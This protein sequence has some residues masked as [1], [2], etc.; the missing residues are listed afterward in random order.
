M[1]EPSSQP[2]ENFHPEEEDLD[3]KEMIRVV[4]SHSSLIFWMTFF[5]LALSGLYAFLWPK[6]YEAETTVKVPDISQTPQGMLRELVPMSGSGDPIETYVEVC[7]S[8]SVAWAV[9]KDLNLASKPDYQDLTGQEIVK[10]LLKGVVKVTN[11]KTSNLLSIAARSH[12]PQLAAALANTWAKEFIAV[13]L[14]LSHE[15]AQSKVDFLEDQARQLKTKLANPNLRLNDESKMDQ[16]IYAQLLEELQQAQI[17]EKVNDAGI[18]VVDEAKAPEKHV[19]PKKLLVLILGLF[20][21]LFG[22]IQLAFIL[23]RL[24]D[25]VKDVEKLKRRTGL[26]NY[27]IVP[28][29]REDYPASFGRPPASERFSSKYLIHNLVFDHAYYRESFKVLRTNITLAKAGKPLKVLS[30]FSPGPEEGKTLASANLSISLAQTG[31]KVLLVDADLRKSSVLKTF[32][33]P[34]NGVKAGLPL[35]LTGQKNWKDMVQPSGVENLDLL[36]NSVSPPN[37]AELLGSEAMKKLVGEMKLSY[38]FVIFDGAPVLPVT[39]SVVLST[40]LDGVILLARFNQTRLAAVLHALDHFQRV[41]VQVLGTVLNDIPL[42]KSI[43]GY[44]GYGYGYG[45]GKP[46]EGKAAK[47]S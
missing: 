20:L 12:D 44:Y 31:K 17:E 6:T 23:E 25:R 24:Q 21:G 19:W 35:A 8:Q 16:V 27:A 11:V 5:V 36:P 45:Y 47:K 40:Y 7:Q 28:D 3:L 13:N 14:D 2:T 10:S 34:V 18:V 15:G 26:P 1:T 37:P 43:Y 33:L 4:F 22:G 46:T 30:V 9:M 39:D 38:D 42:K 41:G 29:L 32:G